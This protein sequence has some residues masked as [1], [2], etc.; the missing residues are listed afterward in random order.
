[1]TD[2]V[3]GAPVERIPLKSALIMV[4]LISLAASV[5]ITGVLAAQMSVGS[6]P[7]LGPKL[8]QSPSTRTPPPTQV[9]APAPLA[10]TSVPP[11]APVQST[12]S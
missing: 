5:M 6:D 7:A 9:V 4:L 12:T 3:K 1:M 10:P 8:K 11:P 2:R